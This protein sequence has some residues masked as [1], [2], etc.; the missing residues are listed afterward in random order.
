[1]ELWI[2]LAI[3]A[4]FFQNIRSALQKHLKGRLSTLG[5]AYVRF[6]G[7]YRS[8]RYKLNAHSGSQMINNIT[9]LNEFLHQS[10]VA[11]I[12]L[13]KIKVGIAREAF[14]VLKAAGAEIIDSCN[15]LTI[16]EQ[17]LGQV[18]TDK[19]RPACYKCFHC[20]SL[21]YAGSRVCLTESIKAKYFS[22]GTYSGTLLPVPNA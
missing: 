5:A 4:A 1:M 9:L 17:T 3:A 13:N 6:N 21:N 19:A 12:A 22:S 14:D 18:R 20:R 7:A 15:L 11:Y 10:S 2:P 8:V 16:V